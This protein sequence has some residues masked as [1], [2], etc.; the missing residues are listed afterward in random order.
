MATGATPPERIGPYRILAPLG[1]G[2]MGIVYRALDEDSGEVIALKTVL[3]P[4]TGTLGSIRREIIALSR[5]RHPGVVRILAQGIEQGLPW[6]AMELVEG[7]TLRSITNAVRRS[8]V[9][10]GDATIVMAPS[11]IPSNAPTVNMR[12]RHPVS[13][14]PTFELGAYE[15]DK[16]HDNEEETAELSFDTRERSAV[17]LRRTPPSPPLTPLTTTQPPATPPTT[18]PPATERDPLP[19]SL[20]GE[21]T[22]NDLLILA[23]RLCGPLAFLHGEG[24]VHRDLKPANVLVRSDGT[25]VLVDFGLVT[26]FGGAKGR[27]ALDVEGTIMGTVEYMAPEQIRGELV[28]AR[29]DLYSLGCMLYEIVTGRLPFSGH[30]WEIAEQHL[31][32]A[33]IPPSRMVPSISIGL[34]RLIMRLLAKQPK[35]RLGYA[36]DVAAALDRLG[37]DPR[38][39]AVGPEPRAYLYRPTFTGRAQALGQMKALIGRSLRGGGGRALIG[40]ES[41]SGKTRL[42][43]EV[44][45]AATRRRFRVVSGECLPV[46]GPGDGEDLR[47]G[48]L[49]PIRPLLQVIA[50]HCRS[51]GPETTKA[52]LG[53]RGKVLALYEPDLARLPGQDAY[54]EPARLQGPAAR[55]RLFDDLGKTLRAFAQE[56]PL[57]L[58]LDDLQWADEL[59]LGMLA[60]LK[61]DFFDATPLV[62]LGTYRNE[63]TSEALRELVRAP[64]TVHIELGRLDEAMVGSIVA[65]MLALPVAPEAVTRFLAAQS[66]GNPFF[67]AEYLRTAVS[68]GLLRRNEHGQWEVPIQGKEA[69]RLTAALPLPGSLRELVS[70]RLERLGPEAQR[71]AEAA[72]VLG[73]ELDADLVAALSGAEEGEVL[74]GIEQLVAR[75]ILEE[76]APGRLRFV[77]DKLREVAYEGID[78]GR[79]Q[80][81][82]RAAAIAIEA[83]EKRTGTLAL[84]YPVLAHHYGMAGLE[85]KTL[86][87]LEAAGERALRTGAHAEAKGFFRRALALDD[88]RRERGLG[89]PAVR[90]ARLERMLGEA[91][92]GLGDLMAARRHMTEALSRL[93][94]R[95]PETRPGWGAFLLGQL[96]R[97][98]GH[99]VTPRRTR[100]LDAATKSAW[101]E[102]VAAAAQLGWSYYFT[103]DSL[104]MVATRLLAVNLAEAAGRPLGVAQSYAQLGYI[105]GLCRLHPLARAY[106][107][108][109]QE[110]ARAEGDA[111]EM[112]FSLY[113]ES[114]YHLGFGDWARTEENARPALEI[115]QQIGDRQEAEMVHTVLGHAEHFTGRFEAAVRRFAGLLES[116]R[117]RSNVQHEAWGLYA[118]ARSMIPLGQLDEAVRM[119]REAQGLLA[120]QADSASV[121]ICE[122]LLAQACLELGRF[123]EA[124]AVADALSEK[125]HGV[126]SAVFSTVHGYAA[127]AEVYLAAWE[128]AKRK[129]LASASVARS[130]QHAAADLRTFAMLFPLG[131]PAAQRLTGEAHRLSGRWGPAKEAWRKALERA[132]ELGMPYEEALAHTALARHAGTEPVRRE[133]QHAA[134]AIFVRLGCERWVK[135]VE[136]LIISGR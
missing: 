19:P 65:D 124:L 107:R 106:F 132:R 15:H 39:P 21:P 112:A 97:Q 24:I 11:G 73:R 75:Q 13:E 57:L 25:P 49:H 42:A 86:E 113:I 104:G 35:D 77:H 54:P 66:E 29:A 12:E 117:Q 120:T 101:L 17:R 131:L 6:Y 135:E 98:V 96:C 89:V 58:V 64:G 61:E 31:K 114:V 59:T 16:E 128:Q 53:R 94:T 43:M 67:V 82:H 111:S 70:R 123:D 127:V 125:T 20:D 93:G 99:L 116:A 85:E 14:A 45:A 40:G 8:G 52:L 69:A 95:L 18:P 115:L 102:A 136:G 105:C 130:A 7:E 50:D 92:N 81:L 48:P 47:A 26:R 55:E 46:R 28:D 72:S 2:G 33:P 34:E 80:R 83:R 5:I 51:K 30:A 118:M 119:L 76:Q 32:S 22:T 63:E 10:I 4:E 9:L 62:I 37:V 122:G 88:E 1:E 133:N 23:R 129:G 121:I 74:S 38:A 3:V 126:V 41:G 44:G 60:S 91:H 71:L 134:L 68:E 87:Y 100:V 103:G 109:A 108:R 90:R 36:S 110:A 56:D 27:E 79:R 78:T 84:A